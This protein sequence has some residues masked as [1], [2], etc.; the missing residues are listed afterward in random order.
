LGAAEQLGFVLPKNDIKG[1]LT[2]EVYIFIFVQGMD[3]FQQISP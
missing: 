3:I 1:S 2:K